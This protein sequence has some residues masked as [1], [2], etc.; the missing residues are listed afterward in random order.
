MAEFSRMKGKEIEETRK[1]KE[2]EKFEKEEA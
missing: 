2:R 1:E